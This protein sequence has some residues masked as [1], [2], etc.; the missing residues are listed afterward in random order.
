MIAGFDHIAITVADL[1]ATCRFYADVLDAV[2]EET[3][4]VE[5]RVVVKRVRIGAAVFNVHQHGNGIEL[6]ARCP[7]PGSAD[8]CLRW[9]GSSDAAKHHLESRNVAIAEGPSPRTTSDGKAGS[10]VYFLDPDGNLIELM[11]TI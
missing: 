9:E 5:G 2:V 10:S 7:T 11:A 8:I 6:V 3:Y 1:D 4:T